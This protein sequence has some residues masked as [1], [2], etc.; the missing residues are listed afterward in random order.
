MLKKEGKVIPR[1]VC[2]KC[3]EYMYAEK[4]SSGYVLICPCCEKAKEAKEKIGF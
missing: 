4:T 2:E 3:L 1:H